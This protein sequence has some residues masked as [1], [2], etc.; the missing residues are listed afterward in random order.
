MHDDELDEITYLW[1]EPLGSGTQ[2]LEELSYEDVE[3]RL[4]QFIELCSLFLIFYCEF[5]NENSK[6]FVDFVSSSNIES[7]LYLCEK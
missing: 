3:A 5:G 2:R 7:S 1:G 6:S 4:K